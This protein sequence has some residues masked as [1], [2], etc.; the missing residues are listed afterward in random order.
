MSKNATMPWSHLV[1]IIFEH[2]LTF[3]ILSHPNES[4]FVTLFYA[5]WQMLSDL[6]ALVKG[7]FTNYLCQQ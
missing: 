3:I 5:H 1:V 2:V 4:Y 7:I 6:L